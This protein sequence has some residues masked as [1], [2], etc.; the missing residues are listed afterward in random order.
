MTE[1]ALARTRLAS[2]LQE[3]EGPL[4]LEDALNRLAAGRAG[5][6]V[7]VDLGGGWTARADGPRGLEGLEQR[8]KGLRLLIALAARD[9]DLRPLGASQPA[10]IDPSIA[11]LLDA[12]KRAR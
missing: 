10:A 12:V 6:G 4:G 2:A 1:Q 11:A 9:G 7:E 5:P 3:P 8:L